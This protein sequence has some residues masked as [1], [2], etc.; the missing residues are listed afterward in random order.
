MYLKNL[1]DEI[2]TECKLLQEEAALLLFLGKQEG[3]HL[4]LDFSPSLISH[5]PGPELEVPTHYSD[6]ST[7]GTTIFPE[8]A[9]LLLFCHL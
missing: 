9:P 1:W 2:N 5:H 8:Y 6:S 7:A 4:L 3:N